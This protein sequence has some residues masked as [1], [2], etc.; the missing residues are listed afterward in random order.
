MNQSKIR[1]E[2]RALK[3]RNRS[4]DELLN[5]GVVIMNDLSEIKESALL[6][7]IELR[8]TDELLNEKITITPLG[9]IEN[10]KWALHDL[11]LEPEY[12]KNLHEGT[13]LYDLY[14]LVED[15]DPILAMKTIYISE[16]D[17]QAD[18]EYYIELD[19]QYR[20]QGY[21]DSEYIH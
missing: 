17:F 16:E 9:A 1:Y 8:D 7:G 4:K 18:V 19:M 20:T 11:E 21:L 14:L 2:I 3:E 15:E 13:N 6:L 10:L 12:I 5:S